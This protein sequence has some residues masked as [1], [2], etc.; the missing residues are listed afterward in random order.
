[1][2]A[3]TISFLSTDKIIQYNYRILKRNLYWLLLKERTLEFLLLGI[4][5]WQS[6]DKMEEECNV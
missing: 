6:N 1:M 2:I 5:N 4:I 3:F